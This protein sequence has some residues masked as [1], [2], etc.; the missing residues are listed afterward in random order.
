MAPNGDRYHYAKCK[1]NHNKHRKL[2]EKW[3]KGV[4]AQN[5]ATDKSPV[6]A[7]VRPHGHQEGVEC[8]VL[9]RSRLLLDAYPVKLHG[10]LH[11]WWHVLFLLDILHPGW[12]LVLL[13]VQIGVDQRF[14]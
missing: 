11:L 13:V 8:Q 1:Y 7:V 6:W 5:K 2:H 10:I 12:K 9:G 14:Q 4:D 3:P